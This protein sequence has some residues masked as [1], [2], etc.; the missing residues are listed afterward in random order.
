MHVQLDEGGV[1]NAAETVNLP[2][3]DDENVPGAGFELLAVDCPEP[4]ALPD[5]SIRSSW[6][7]TSCGVPRVMM[8]LKIRSSRSFVLL[9]EKDEFGPFVPP[10]M[11]N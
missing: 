4:S 9:V 2:R 5:V 7:V 10:R 3:F 6:S 11:S 8:V 1:A